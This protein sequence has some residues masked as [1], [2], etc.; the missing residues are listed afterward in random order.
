MIKIKVKQLNWKDLEV[1]QNELDLYMKYVAVKELTNDFL[2]TMITFDMV[3][4]LYYLLRNR[5]E[6]NN[7]KY[8]VSFTV[9]Q[10]A[11][12]LKCCHFK[13]IDRD[14]FT[15]H[16]MTKLEISLDKQLRDLV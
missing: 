3:N 12:I 5:L 2:N 8:N 11:T 10:A 15:K 14:E 16:V 4:N 1:L 7:T 9:S 6:Q 13:R